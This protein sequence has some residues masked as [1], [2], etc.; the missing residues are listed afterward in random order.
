[1]KN[2]KRDNRS[3]SFNGPK[4][5]SLPKFVPKFPHL[6]DVNAIKAGESAFKIRVQFYNN[7][8]KENPLKSAW[9]R[10]FKRAEREFNDGLRRSARIL[11]TIGFEEEEA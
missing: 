1:M 7:P 2:H 9:I 4:F 5:I 11:D 6:T 3:K 10:G 8:Y